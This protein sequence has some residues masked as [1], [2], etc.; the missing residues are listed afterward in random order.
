MLSNVNIEWRITAFALTHPAIIALRIVQLEFKF[1]GRRCLSGEVFLDNV[2]LINDELVFQILLHPIAW[3]AR[4]HA[5]R[6]TSLTCL[7]MFRWCHV[8]ELVFNLEDA[9]F[10]GSAIL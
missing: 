9:W 1:D 4:R 8:G 10:G 2:L 3:I 5:H 7:I 6:A